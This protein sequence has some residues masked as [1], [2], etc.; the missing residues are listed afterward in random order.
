M[1]KIQRRVFMMGAATAA[2]AT[3]QVSPNEKLVVAVM[4]LRGRGGH[5]LRGFAGMPQF[6]VAAISD[7]DTRLLDDKSIDVLVVGT[8]DHGRGPFVQLLNLKDERA[9]GNQTGLAS[10]CYNAEA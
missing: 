9:E 7:V 1:S 5:L 8:P 2:A 6:D 4:G 3:G 10:R